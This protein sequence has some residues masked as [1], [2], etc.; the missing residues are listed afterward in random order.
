MKH[1]SSFIGIAVL[2]LTPLGIFAQQAGGPSQPPAEPGTPP[3]KIQVSDTISVT[4][5]G[6]V[7]TE[8][9]VSERVIEEAAPGT[10]PIRIVSQL[11]SV[12]YTSADPY[13]AYEWAVRISI[14]VSYTHLDVYKRQA[15]S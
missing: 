13:G 1:C 11:P 15:H 10:S 2:L 3:A 7:R 8:Q 9:T 5:P 4:A 12:N 14:P 6:E